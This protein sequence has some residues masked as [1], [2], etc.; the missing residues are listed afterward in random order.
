MFR[1]ICRV[2]LRQKTGKLLCWGRGGL[3]VCAGS[4]Q[5]R[6][7]TELESQIHSHRQGVCSS[8]PLDSFVGY[9][10]TWAQLNKHDH[11]L[12]S[13]TGQMSYFSA[14]GALSGKLE[15]LRGCSPL[16]SC[17]TWVAQLLWVLQATRAPCHAQAFWE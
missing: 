13:L 8:P 14:C 6:V 15:W 5:P 16:P 11:Y 1:Y 4:C 2:N 9:P 17:S 3:L 12:P 10:G 7:S